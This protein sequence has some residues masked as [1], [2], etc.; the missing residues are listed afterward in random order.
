LS[1]AI[2]LGVVLFNNS[3]HEV[4]RLVRA[5]T[6]N[7][8]PGDVRQEWFWWD[9]SGTDRLR[10]ELEQTRPGQ[11]YW[12]TGTNVGF[13]VAHNRLMR[14]AFSR[15][16]CLW[17]VCVN[18]DALLHPRCLLELIQV[19]GRE[20]RAGLVEARLFPDEHPKQYDPI[21]LKTAWC[22]GCVL[23]VTRALYEAIGG[24]DENFFIYCEDVD[25]SWRAQAAGF[26]T[27]IAP[28]ALVHHYAQGRP[29]LKERELAVRRSAAYLA[30][31][32]GATEFA[33]RMLTEYQSLGGPSFELSKLSPKKAPHGSFQHLLRFSE[34]RW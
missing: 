20:P 24:F 13:S 8:V 23:L 11:R 18:P 25:L 30:N 5:F 32:Y 2:A 1:K 26:K 12:W 33:R 34:S 9:N 10:R 21:T 31:K 6:A 27:L 29:I 16:E 7:R 14:E 4:C 3:T 28:A 22:S 19:A 17:Y 15:D